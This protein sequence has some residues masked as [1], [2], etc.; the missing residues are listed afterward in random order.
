MP[1]TQ[2]RQD[3]ITRGLTACVL[4]CVRA[5]LAEHGFR[6]CLETLEGK[7]QKLEETPADQLTGEHNF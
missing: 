6:F 4:V 5:E 2:R 3:Q 1:L 7:V